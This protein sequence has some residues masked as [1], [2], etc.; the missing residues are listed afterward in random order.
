MAPLRVREARRAHLTQ[1][2]VR[3]LATIVLLGRLSTFSS[4]KP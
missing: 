3:A 1:R 2:A 4:L